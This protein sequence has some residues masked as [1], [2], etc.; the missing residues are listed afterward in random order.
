MLVLYSTST[1]GGPYY[2]NSSLPLTLHLSEPPAR[3]ESP[4]RIVF[5]DPAS[6][7]VCSAHRSSPHPASV[8]AELGTRLAASV[9]LQGNKYR[10]SG[11]HLNSSLVP[12]LILRFVFKEPFQT[13]A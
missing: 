7:P 11:T 10:T 12:F 5:A 1:L 6:P 9:V 4:G 2:Y 13:V 3:T 8:P